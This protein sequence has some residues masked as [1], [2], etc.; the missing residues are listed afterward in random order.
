MDKLNF[1]IHQAIAPHFAGKATGY[2]RNFE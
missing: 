2:I 1:E